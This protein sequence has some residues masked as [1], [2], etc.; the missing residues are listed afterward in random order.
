MPC[1]GVLTTQYGRG[2]SK[3]KFLHDFAAAWGEV[4]DLYRIDLV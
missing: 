1:D 2:D 4:M 3:E